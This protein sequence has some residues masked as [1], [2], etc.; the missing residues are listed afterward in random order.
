MNSITILSTTSS[1]HVV[2]AYHETMNALT[3]QR[4]DVKHV[5]I[6]SDLWYAGN[7]ALI[8]ITKVQGR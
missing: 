5:G 4:F 3:S 1:Q 6:A 7:A 8:T 2:D